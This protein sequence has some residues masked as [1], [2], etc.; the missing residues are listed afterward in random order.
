MGNG[1]SRSEFAPDGEPPDYTLAD[2]HSINRGTCVIRQPLLKFHS[3]HGENIQILSAG[4][5]AR[6]KD[7]FCKSLAFSNRPILVDEV[8]C[9]KL[10]EVSDAWSGVLRFGVTSV[11]PETFRDVE[12]PKFA[13]PDLTSKSGFWAKALPDRYCVQNCILHFMVNSEGTLHYGINGLSKGVFLNRINVN[14]NLWAL[15]D[16]YGNSKAIEFVDTASALASEVMLSRNSTIIPPDPVD[17]RPDPNALRFHRICGVNAQVDD[18]RA[19]YVF[20]SRPIKMDE[21]MTIIVIKYTSDFMGSMAFGLTSCD[22]A[23]IRNIADLP[24]DSDNLLERPEYWVSI[25]T[26]AREAVRQSAVET[27]SRLSREL[28]AMRVELPPVQVGSLGEDRSNAALEMERNLANETVER[29]HSTHSNIQLRSHSPVLPA[30]PSS[31]ASPS[32]YP[33]LGERVEIPPLTTSITRASTRSPA[34][35]SSSSSVSSRPGHAP[36]FRTDRTAGA[37]SF[38]T[39]RNLGVLLETPDR[40]AS[41]PRFVS[42]SS[43]FADSRISCSPSSLTSSAGAAAGLPSSS[44]A[45][46]VA[47][48][49]AS[50]ATPTITTPTDGSMKSERTTENDSEC[51]ICMS[52]K[53][54]AVLY[55]CGHLCC[56]FACAKSTMDG[57]GQCPLCRQIIMDVIR[58]YPG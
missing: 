15:W 34:V 30:R 48:E 53:A 13:C 24:T 26:M 20:T 56:C 19:A 10:T 36:S 12:L 4:R 57:S 58:C 18:R 11:D 14:T 9:V 25:R 32:V 55:R 37:R 44:S 52:E 42:S 38:S 2:E 50:A 28:A 43:R 17:T 29:T 21:Q 47:E 41:A 40:P 16:I 33:V 1:S 35:Y 27:S 3:V 23:S 54:N 51:I 7:S 39:S 8:V 5:R 49:T 46:V 31:Y 6:R 22:P 45:P